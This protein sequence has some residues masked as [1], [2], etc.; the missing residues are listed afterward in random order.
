[1][2]VRWDVLDGAATLT[3]H[4][5]GRG[6]TPDKGIRDS[7]YGLVGMRERADVI[8]ARILVRSSPGQGTT[9]TVRA[10]QAR[11]EVGT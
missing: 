5:D 1:V 7:A 3:I 9:I 4:D 2:K 6:F 8:G 10:G 11:E